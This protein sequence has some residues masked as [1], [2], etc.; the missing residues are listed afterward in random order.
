MQSLKGERESES[1]KFEGEKHTKQAHIKYG[2]REY[3]FMSCC[4]FNRSIKS[5]CDACF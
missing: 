2:L 1:E 4:W 3:A 5:G